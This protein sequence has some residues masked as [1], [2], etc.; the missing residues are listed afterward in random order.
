MAAGNGHAKP[1][2]K[3]RLNKKKRKPKNK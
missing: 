3:R 1:N 2:K